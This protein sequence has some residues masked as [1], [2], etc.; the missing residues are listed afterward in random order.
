MSCP[1]E[2]TYDEEAFMDSRRGASQPWCPRCEAY[3]EDCVCGEEPHW[4]CGCGA[5]DVPISRL[6]GKVATCR[7][8]GDQ[9]NG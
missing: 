9:S 8:C 6:R 7:I 3:E 4:K 2:F 5:C 1:D